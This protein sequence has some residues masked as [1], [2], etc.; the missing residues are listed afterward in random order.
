MLK[1]KIYRQF[2][3]YIGFCIVWFNL[4]FVWKSSKQNIMESKTTIKK[5]DVVKTSLIALVLGLTTI[6]SKP[7][8][9]FLQERYNKK[10]AYVVSNTLSS[11][12]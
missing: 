4:K 1:L 3:Y 2:Y 5:T 11:I 6:Y 12:N 7:I 9:D 10:M 8:S